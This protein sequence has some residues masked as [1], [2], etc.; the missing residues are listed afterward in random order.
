MYGMELPRYVREYQRDI[1]NY[2]RFLR[3]RRSLDHPG[4]Y[5]V[6]RKTRYTAFPDIS[7]MTDRAVQHKDHYRPILLVKPS[8][9][10]YVRR[11]L[12]LTD[13]QRLGGAKAVAEMLDSVDDRELDLLD[14]R[15]RGDYEA[16]SGDAYDWLAWREGRRVATHA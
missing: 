15:I 10:R 4:L 16:I 7:L 11:H 3:I 2:D 13:I 12:A 9:L 14:R 5:L 6:E 1:R 8:E